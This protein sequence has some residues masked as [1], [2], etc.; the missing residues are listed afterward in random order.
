VT[1][2]GVRSA[3]RSSVRLFAER[4]IDSSSG[5]EVSCIVDLPVGFLLG[6]GGAI[7]TE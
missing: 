3:G 5:E 2:L 1:V 6:P 4:G 7:V